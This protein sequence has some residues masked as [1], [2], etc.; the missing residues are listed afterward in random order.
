M[1][2]ISNVIICPQ[3]K[4]SYPRKG[5]LLSYPPKL[6][7]KALYNTTKRPQYAPANHLPDEVLKAAD[8]SNSDSLHFLVYCKATK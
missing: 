3:P 7:A 1:N 8:L 4:I 6:Q 5:V 2:Y